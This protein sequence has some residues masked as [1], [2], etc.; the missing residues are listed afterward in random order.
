VPPPEATV[1]E[2]GDYDPLIRF[3]GTVAAVAVCADIGRPTHAQA[4]ADR[5]ARIYLASMFVIPSDFDGEMAKL[6]SYALRHSMMVAFANFG[7]P[8]GGLASAG[9]SAIWS[10]TGERLVQ[11]DTSGAGVAV[12]SETE[13]GWRARTVMLTSSSVTSRPE[14]TPPR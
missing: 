13:Q 5:G 9:R 14:L 1:F 11:L 6:R 2:P 10:G 7:S 4:A 3:D 12:V 8:S